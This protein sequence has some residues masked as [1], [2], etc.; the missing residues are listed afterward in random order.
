[1]K[2]QILGS[3]SRGNSCIIRTAESVF[4]LDNGFSGKEL[5]RRL[6][7][8]QIAPRDIHG[9]LVSH[10]HTDH[11][12]GVGVFARKYHTPVYLNRRTFEY[13]KRTLFD[14]EVE[15]FSAG[16]TVT[17]RDLQVETFSLPHDAGDPVGFK[18]S[19]MH[20]RKR[21]PAKKAGFVTDLGQVTPL[22]R[23]KLNDIH[24]LIIETNHD[25]HM[26][27][28]GPYPWSLKQR[29]SSRTGHLSNVA[30]ARL[31]SAV[32]NHTGIGEV[33]L[34]HLSEKNNDPGLAADAVLA[35]VE[36]DCGT[37]IEVNIAS[38][39]EPMDELIL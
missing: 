37:P 38:Q 26:L 22:I 28:H 31:I 16:Q 13:T 12:R 24:A 15:F 5:V 20:G 36:K 11:I 33:T 6:D 39:Q 21:S 30:A 18:F 17:F 14:T 34:A 19:Q 1:M 7:A 35:Q 32:V 27:M 9:I 23:Q 4:L 29:V 3:G 25:E 10:D 8:V 2:I